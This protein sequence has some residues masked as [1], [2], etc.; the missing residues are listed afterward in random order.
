MPE[1]EDEVLVGWEHGDF[2]HPFVLGYLWNGQDPTPDND[3]QNRVLVTPGGHTLRFEDTS[4]ARQIVLRTAGGHEIVL[5]DTAAGN[6]VEIATSGGHHLVLDDGG[7]S[8]QVASAG[9]QSLTIDDTAGS[10]TLVG[11][12]RSIA[13]SG[14]QVQIT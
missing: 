4:G 10:T 12:G 11:G 5:S 3:P 14:G 7:A 1:P 13:L 6:K 2:D 8:I 9:G